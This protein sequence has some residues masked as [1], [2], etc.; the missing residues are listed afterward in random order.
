MRI[1]RKVF[2][3]LAIWQVAFGLGIGAAFPFFVMA[4]G[5]PRDTALTPV[6]ITACLLAGALSG[7]MNQ[8]IS[9]RVVAARLRVLVDSMTHVGKVLDGAAFSGDLSRC[10]PEACAIAVDSEDEIGESA[11]AFNRLVEALA[12][13]MRAQA[14]V[15]SFSDM[16]TSQLEIEGLAD[17]ALR[18][19]VEHTNAAAGLVLHQ[20]EGELK[21]AASRGLKDPAAIV[22]NDQ[23]KLAADRGDR[24]VISIPEDVLVD[25]VMADFRPREILVFPIQHKSVPLGVVVLAASRPFDADERARIDLFVQGL[26]LAL[27]NAVAHD[28]LQ[29]LAALDSLTGIYNRRFGLGRLREEFGRA[30]RAQT[31]LGVLMLDIDHFKAIND[32][33]GHLAGDRLLKAVAAIARSSLR[34]GDVLLRYGGEEF[35]AVLPAASA[36]DLRALG[37]RLRRAVEDFSLAEGEKTVHVTVSVGGAAYPDPTIDNEDTLIRLADEALYR[38]KDG[39]RNRVE[40]TSESELAARAAWSGV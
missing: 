39:G 6:F 35:A 9:H 37:E 27:N 16:L 24:Q 38:A 31:P 29:R 17:H 7:V 36:A 19:F 26:G 10:T 15:R 4:L 23:V 1:T 18:Q 34:E 2:T 30:V 12:Q 33:Y 14:A 28:R 13:S 20:S 25:G 21:I 32:T 11:Q 5:V 8:F 22:V 40:V 3:D